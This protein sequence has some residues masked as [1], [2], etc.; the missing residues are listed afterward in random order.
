MVGKVRKIKGQTGEGAL[1]APAAAPPIPKP[2]A[3]PAAKPSRRRF[4]EEDITRTFAPGVLKQARLLLAKDHVTIDVRAPTGRLS[5]TVTDGAVRYRVWLEVEE[6]AKQSL[7][8]STCACEA[9]ACVHAAA[10]A[11]AHFERTPALHRPVQ[12]SLLDLLAPPIEQVTLVYCLDVAEGDSALYITVSN[13]ISSAQGRSL[14]TITPRRAA[15][16]LGDGPEHEADRAI[17]LMLGRTSLPLVAVSFSDPALVDLLIR[18][19]VDT[20]RSR[21]QPT[22]ARLA[23]GP[24]QR[25]VTERNPRTDTCRVLNPPL[26]TRVIFSSPAWYVE[27]R[28]GRI[29]RAVIEEVASRSFASVALAPGPFQRGHHEPLIVECEPIPVL[30]AVSGHGEEGGTAAG[31]LDALMLQ[32][33][34]AGRMV[35]EE[36][37]GQ[38][39]RIEGD[40]GP[41]FLRRDRRAEELAVNALRNLGLTAVRLRL[42]GAENGCRAHAFRNR[43]ARDAQE[44]WQDFV[45]TGSEE[46]RAK[47]WKVELGETFRCRIVDVTDDWDIDVMENGNGW[48][49]LNIGIEVEGRKQPLL[50]ILIG[51]LERGGMAAAQVA[52]GKIRV[53]MDD[54]RILALPAERVAKFLQT[55]EEMIAGNGMGKDGRLTLSNSEAPTLGDLEAIVG[56]RWHGGEDLRSLGRRLRAFD[57]PL[58]VEPPS[59]FKATLRPYQRDGLDWLQF[60]RGHSMAG[61]LADDMGLGKTAQ[62]LAH[63]AVE[64]VSGRLTRPCLI[65]VPT[66]LV[67][68]WTAEAAKFVPDLRVVVFHGL[69]RHGRRSEVAEGELVVTTYAILARDIDFLTAIHWHMVVLDEAQAIKNP[70]AKAT[71][72]ACRLQASHRLCLSG[73][74]IENHLGEVWSQFAFLM[75][76]LLGDHRRFVAHYR[77][78]IEKKGDGERRTQLAKRLRPFMLRRTKAEVATD[79]P[80]KTE[81]AHRV[82][83]ASDQR[84]LYETIRLSMHQRVREEIARLGIAR[85]Q[86]VILDAL[87][88]LRQVCCDPRLVKLESARKVQ[89]SGKLEALME[90]LPAM[91]EEGRRVLL[92]SQFTSML[93]LI[94]QALPPTGITYVELRGQTVD[95]ATP[96]LR[97]Q[98]CEVPLFLISLKAGGRGLNLTA[99][100]TVIHY[101]P[102]WNPAIE[103]QATDRAHRIGQNKAVFVYKLIAAGT[104]EERII[105][106][107]QRKGALAEALLDEGTWV[108]A[109]REDDL[110]FLFDAP[111]GFL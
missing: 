104:V 103:N 63:I 87:L 29:G 49:S 8:N 1:I 48:F 107:Q 42:V 53:R 4:A 35:R 50:P 102:W 27:E 86:I 38:F 19:L 32:F 7:L 88:K 13:Q 56:T 6:K 92:F 45:L 66:S 84:D 64:K 25:F 58:K 52:E 46:L 97:F 67:P 76:G 22:G 23:H 34:Y 5:A 101:D 96:V 41:L 62:T 78:P 40:D 33:D 94:K 31:T 109:L 54:G 83:L 85:S 95:R 10:A 79:L 111:E 106:L 39:A 73:T 2:V 110:E 30:T 75:P 11:L 60:L 68:N 16:A 51:I 18:R 3:K 91:I 99:A 70:M 72:A 93:D 24:A 28:T 77:T 47:G 55:L 61:I 105:E 80:P 90:M 20:G 98:A 71:R 15:D 89:G 26:K 43:D 82:E 21:W 12:T 17:C 57:T 108:G 36:E 81:I 44:I 65:V 37:A 9:V 14:K 100:D 74:P 59:S 69:D